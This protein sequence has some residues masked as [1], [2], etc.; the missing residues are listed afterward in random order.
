MSGANYTAG[1]RTC[2]VLFINGRAVD[3]PPL[4]RSLEGLYATLLPK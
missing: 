4:K 2:L 3:C 1:K